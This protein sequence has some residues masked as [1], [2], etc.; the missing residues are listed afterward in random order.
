MKHHRANRKSPSD[1]LTVSYKSPDLFTNAATDVSDSIILTDSKFN[2]TGWNPTTEFL[3]GRNVEEAKGKHLFEIINIS[4]PGSSLNNMIIEIQRT[5]YWN[6]EVVYERYDN[7]VFRLNTSAILVYNDINVVSGCVI[8][9]KIISGKDHHEEKLLLAESKYQTVIDTLFEGVVI[10]NTDGSIGASNH[11]AAEILG[12]S[13]EELVGK[14]TTSPVWKAIN[15]DGS[16]FPLDKFPGTVTLKT[17]LGQENITM[18]IERPDGKLVWLLVNSQAIVEQGKIVAV[19]A[20][21]NDITANKHA[22]D[23]IKESEALFRTFMNNSNAYAWICDED[24]ILVYTNSLFASVYNLADGGKDKHISEV[25][26]EKVAEKFLEKNKQFLESNEPKFIIA[27]SKRLDGTIGKF[28]LYRF[29]IPVKTYKRLIGFQAFDV[30]DHQD[31][32]AELK[33]TNERFGL[34][35][36]ATSDAIWDQDLETNE[37]YRSPNFSKLSGYSMQEI[38]SNLDWWFNKVHPD[39]K[40]RVRGKVQEYLKVNKQSWEDEYRFLCSDG[41]YKTLFDKGFFIYKDGK[42]VRIIGAIQDIT[43]RKKLEEQLLNEKIKQQ[44]LINRT[45]IAAQEEERDNISKELHDNVNQLLM[46]TKLY[47]NMA[48]KQPDMATELLLKAE[49][50]QLQAVEEIRKLSKK[51]NS[52]LVKVLG[53]KKS[54]QEIVNSFKQLNDIPVNYEFDSE[55]EDVLMDEQKLM[56]FRIVQEQSNNIRKYANAERV[57]INLTRKDDRI[58][59]LISD[60]GVGFKVDESKM[61]GIGLTN[62]ASRVNVLNGEFKIDSYPGNGCTLSVCF[63]LYA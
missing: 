32:L 24:G 2:V 60:D 37:I 54:I 20:S 38:Q 57:S 17:G 4:F 33:K 58:C 61:R 51:L 53:L 52:S 7:Q 28:A 39:D 22:N 44:K 5:G 26:S 14:L 1:N 47:I 62:I 50:Y 12:F 31:T 41:K 46:S 40:D 63:P 18:G 21:F 23:R 9:S 45:T 10:I 55:L 56:I 25:F 13:Q 3:F 11:R 16:E 36:N 29:H 34:I 8:V 30:T 59:L 15:E 19:V 48:R 42:P 6:G 35:S 43:E 27:E 49:E